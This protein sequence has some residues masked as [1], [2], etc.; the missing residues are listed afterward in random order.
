MCCHYLTERSTAA[1]CSNS[2]LVLKTDFAITE[3]MDFVFSTCFLESY[4]LQIM[5]NLVTV[6]NHRGSMRHENMHMSLLAFKDS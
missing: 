1:H 3:E 5:C 6:A 2:S 4:L